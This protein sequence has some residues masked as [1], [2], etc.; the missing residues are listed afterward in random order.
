MLRHNNLFNIQEGGGVY[1]LF[2]GNLKIH[3]Q[4]NI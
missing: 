4:K 1:I 3:I 2:Y